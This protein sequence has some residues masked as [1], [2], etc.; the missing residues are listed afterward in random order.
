VYLGS[1]LGSDIKSERGTSSNFVIQLTAC[2]SVQTAMADRVDWY[3]QPLAMQN[4]TQ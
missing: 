4:S 3:I 2:D 1:Y